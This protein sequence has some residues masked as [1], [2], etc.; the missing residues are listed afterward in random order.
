MV[1]IGEDITA[2]GNGA[3]GIL[4]GTKSSISISIAGDVKATGTT[5]AAGISVYNNGKDA[6]TD[7]T[8]GGTVSATGESGHAILVENFEQGAADPIITVWKIESSDSL[9]SVENDGIEDTEAEERIKS[10][11]NYIIK[12]STTIDGKEAD[13]KIVLTSECNLGE[14]TIGSGDNA[15]TYKTAN[16]DQQIIINVETV[17]GYKSTVQNNGAGILTFNADGTYTLTIPEGGGVS[18]EAVLE[19]IEQ[20]HSGGSSSGSGTTSSATYIGNWMRDNT[21][22]MA[23]KSNGSYA[24]S[25]WYQLEWNGM[26]SW[27]HFNNLGYAEGGWFTDTD[28][29]RYYLSNAHDGSFGRM[30]TGWNQIDGQ[31]YFFNTT[32]ANGSS[33][34]SLAINTTTPDG[35]TVNADGVWVQ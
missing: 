26:T 3:T 23:K 34:G 33:M 6:V 15:K 30:C 16:K 27:Y 10:N 24:S 4:V 2:E 11:I 12:A 32:G 28:G 13:N 25:E 17:K 21:G 5:E 20:Y 9:V 18:L 14:V 19:K 35:Y 31:W 22:W 8:V 1:K 7:V 29:Q